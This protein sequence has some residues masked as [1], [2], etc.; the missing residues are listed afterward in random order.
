MI[1]LIYNTSFGY[2]YIY[3]YSLYSNINSLICGSLLQRL[4]LSLI[5]RV[6]HAM[7]PVYS[8]KY[9]KPNKSLVIHLV[10]IDVPAQFKSLNCHPVIIALIKKEFI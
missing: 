3:I 1:I 10:N 7:L 9:Y 5:P 2:Q 4:P 6:S 8:V